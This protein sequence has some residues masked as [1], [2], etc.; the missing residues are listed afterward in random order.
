M[1]KRYL[2]F[3]IKKRDERIEN[4]YSIVLKTIFPIPHSATLRFPV[5]FVK[6]FFLMNKEGF[7]HIIGMKS[8]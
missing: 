8:L 1:Q 4:I 7:F 5:G 2:F 6:N 3:F